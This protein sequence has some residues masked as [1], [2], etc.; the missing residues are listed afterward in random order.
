MCVNTVY[1]ISNGKLAAKFQLFLADWTLINWVNYFWVSNIGENQINSLNC[2]LHLDFWTFGLL[3]IW[4]F[5]SWE[6]NIQYSSSACETSIKFGLCLFLKF[7]D[8]EKG[9]LV[10]QLLK[11]KTFMIFSEPVFK[12][13]CNVMSWLNKSKW[14]FGNL[15]TGSHHSVGSIGYQ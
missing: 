12:T 2:Y 5:L 11:K 1:L 8:I 15:L 10:R 4:T 3:E 6:G 13:E 9:V 7:T 14:N